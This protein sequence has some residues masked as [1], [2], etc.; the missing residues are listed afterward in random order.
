MSADRLEELRHL[1]R[2]LEAL[3]ASD[4]RDHVLRAARGRAV[5]V[6]T[7]VA[8]RAICPVEPA[9]AALRGARATERPVR[10]GVPLAVSPEGWQTPLFRPRA[11]AFRAPPRTHSRS[12]DLLMAEG[13]LCLEDPPISAALTPGGSARDGWRRG[14][15][16]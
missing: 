13:R 8:P 10:R 16:G 1:V 4:E 5:D 2:R 12:I 3:P 6:D 7:G 15:R 9:E 11:S 14:L